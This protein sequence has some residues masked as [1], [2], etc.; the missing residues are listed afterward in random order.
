[1]AN[2]IDTRVQTDAKDWEGL[3]AAFFEFAQGNYAEIWT[4][5]NEDQFM[6]LI[7]DMMAYLGDLLTYYLDKQTS[8]NFLTTAQLRQ[9]IID[10][11]RMLDYV[12]ESPAPSSGEVTFTIDPGTFNYSNPIPESFRVSNS[13]VLLYETTSETYVTASATSATASVIEG[14]TKRETTV[15]EGPVGESNGTPNQ[16]FTLTYLNVIL[17]NNLTDL[18]SDIEVSV[19]GVIYTPVFNIVTAQSTDKVYVINTD[20]NGATTITFGNGIFGEIPANGVDIE[21]TYRVLLTDREDN[22]YG[23]LNAA[24]INTLE[25]ELT[26][27][28]AV[29]NASS[30]SGGRA[31]ESI[32]EART[33]ISESVKTGDRAVSSEDFI[34]IAEAYTG[35]AKAAALKGTNDL[36][37]DL[38]LAPDGG[39]DPSQA[40]KNAI[41]THFGSRKMV[42]TQIFPRDPFYQPVLLNLRITA[43]PNNRNTDVEN[44]IISALDDLFAFDNMDFGQGVYLKTT[45]GS[46]IFDLNE[47]LEEVSGIASIKY[48]KVTLKPTIYNKKF[49]NSGTP[50]LLG[51][52]GIVKQGSERKEYEVEMQ[53]QTEYLMKSKIFGISTSLNDTR[54]E[55][56]L[57]TF[58]L[59]SGTATDVGA[60]YLT[61]VDK[62]FSTNQFQY[63]TL[64]DSAGTHFLIVSNTEDTLTVSSGTPAEGAYEIVTRLVG[65]YLNPNADQT[66]TFLITEN[67]GNSVTVASGLSEVSVIGNSYE[68][69]RY[70]TNKFHADA[71]EGTETSGAA[72]NT[73][74]ADS[75]ATGPGDDFY[76]GMVVIFQDGPAANIPVEVID[77]VDA[78]GTFTVQSLGVGIT[79]TLSDRYIVAPRYE[80]GV[81]TAVGA[82][83]SPTTVQF[84]GD[85]LGGEGD[86]FYNGYVVH[87]LDGTN[88]GL[89]R[90]VTDYDDVGQDLLTV[91]D[92]PNPPS[93]GDTFQLAKEYQTD[94]QTLSFAVISTNVSSSDIYIF[95]V[96]ELIGDLVPRANQILEL[97]SDD[98]TL[99]VVG[100]S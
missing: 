6:V 99:S 8:E 86:D 92:F 94:D 17:S 23:N 47:A 45:G 93:S 72:T 73:T 4:D 46:D 90:K 96:S 24:A 55:D 85:A 67:D 84:T 95:Q 29:T 91:N 63:Q 25:D 70:E 79:P 56:N 42:R 34:T 57:K 88:D 27:V 44:A 58:S 81:K 87:F 97:D 50:E 33:N 22:S 38:Y 77:F 41:I 32:E 78:T 80:L 26:G 62:F 61:D 39:G 2:V 36:D 7:A 18:P 71:R 74:F 43:E 40:L 3:R 28:T 1:M 49:T 19:G 31:E 21:A 12:L 98:V 51:N 64:I 35:V 75:A 59:E 68:V 52:S 48:N 5:F 69:F 30:F 9:S 60:L 10:I 83:P 76:N 37:I 16:E 13:G 15:G 82:V 100:G 65:Y 20:E 14:E 11:G 66:S 54:L 89:S 53:N